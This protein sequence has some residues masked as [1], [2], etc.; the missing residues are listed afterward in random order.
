[1]KS[2]LLPIALA[3]TILSGCGS[4]D[5]PTP[6]TE[7]TV[8]LSDYGVIRVDHD[9]NTQ[10]TR[11]DAVFCELASPTRA[12][13]ID[14]EFLPET[15]SCV[16]SN[17]GPSINSDAT[18]LL[19]SAA[20]PAQSISAGENLTFSSSAGTFADLAQEISIDNI[21]YTTT[22][23]LPRPPAGL[24]LD[25]PGD[26]FPSF[27]SV[28]I[29]DLQD[30]EIRTPESGE[31]L[32]SDTRLRWNAASDGSDSRLLLS[33]SDADVTVTCSLADDG[34]FS[35]SDATQAEL[36]DLFA[37][38]SLTVR[39]QNFTSPTRGDSGLVIITSI[40]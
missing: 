28:E 4:D 40:Q 17:S 19:C 20:L 27:S 35:F 22:S 7:D 33:A 12:E 23:P 1:M 11:L 15:D 37:A 16:V 21:T 8:E 29:P 34:S 2:S 26:T 3:T 13:S 6:I 32:R 31:P 39:R 25:I 9:T 36:G 38:S 30:L 5:S 24:T 18:P 14:E 10:Q